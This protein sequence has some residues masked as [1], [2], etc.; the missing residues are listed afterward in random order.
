AF[1]RWP[2]RKSALRRSALE[3]SAPRTTTS[4]K[5]SPARTRSIT[6]S[7]VLKIIATLLPP[8]PG[9][10]AS[11]YPGSDRIAS[12]RNLSV[13][14][15]DVASGVLGGPQRFPEIVEPPVDIF[16]VLVRGSGTAQASSGGVQFTQ[17]HSSPEDRRFR[18]D[19]ENRSADEQGGLTRRT[20][21]LTHGLIEE[22]L[23][24]VP[25]G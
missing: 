25:A 2:R 10:G 18:Q 16:V 14:G 17:G 23:P 19:P 22:S 20:H 3:R 5:G 11:S 8:S 9:C 21:R 12:N 24:K 6:A 15:H 4:L 7:R 1:W 13:H